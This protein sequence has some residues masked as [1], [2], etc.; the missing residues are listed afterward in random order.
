[1][2]SYWWCMVLQTTRT[3]GICWVE[4]QRARFQHAHQAYDAI[5][6]PAVASIFWPLAPFAVSV[7]QSSVGPS[8]GTFPRTVLT[9]CICKLHW[10]QTADYSK[11]HLRLLR[12]GPQNSTPGSQ[13]LWRNTLWPNY[14]TTS[15]A[16]QDGYV[17]PPCFSCIPLAAL[18]SQTSVAQ[19][20]KNVRQALKDALRGRE[21]VEYSS[22][23]F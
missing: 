4:R 20:P 2:W 1:M 21:L 7:L 12:A 16:R 22:K 18:K 13:R 11:A 10:L 5:F 8:A 9:C 19:T 3:Y 23:N 14:A 15:Q 17:H 6:Q